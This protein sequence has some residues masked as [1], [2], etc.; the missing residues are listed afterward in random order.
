MDFIKKNWEKVLL[1]A[2]LLGLLF[3][4]IGLPIKIASEKEQLE[5][6]RNRITAG[7]VNPIDDIKVEEVEAAIA[8]TQQPASLDLTV[9]N[10]VVNPVQWNRTPSGQ[11]IK[12]MKGDEVGAEAV[13]VEAIS[14][15][16]LIITLDSVLTTD[17]G[18]RYAIGVEKQAETSRRARGKR[19]TYAAVGEKND[20]FLL[21]EVKGP[22]A[23]PTAVDLEL[24]DTGERI[25][26]S[27]GK[28]F[29]RVDG[30]MA[31]LAYPPDSRRWVGKRVGDTIPIER[32]T[33]NIVA[34]TKDEVVL[35]ARTGKKTSL[36]SGSGS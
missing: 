20:V 34:I 17:S 2:V 12:V 3:A 7:P 19:Q 24:S 21:R 11:L 4:V 30:Y 9:S 6:V 15:L 26:I 8:R 33:Y 22:P 28:P 10:R 18:S 5:E 25:T 23:Q 29:R 16:Y 13:V 1:G 36:K 35:S 14:P 32:E 31:D 27:S